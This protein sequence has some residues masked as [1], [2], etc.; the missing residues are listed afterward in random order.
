MEPFS[1]HVLL[2][3]RGLVLRAY[4]S[5]VDPDAYPVEG[6]PV[7]TAAYGLDVFIDRYL[8]PV[9]TY[10]QPLDI[11]AVHDAGN[12][13]RRALYPDYKLKR[14]E[15][16]AGEFEKQQ[17]DLL[18]RLVRDLLAQLGCLQVYCE[19]TEA[20]DVVAYLVEKLHGN[21]AIYTVDEDLVQLATPDGVTV[22]RGDDCFT[23][24]IHG[25]PAELLVLRKSIIGDSSDGYGGVE[26][27]GPKGFDS[28]RDDF[29]IDGLY[30][31]DKIVRTQDWN[32]LA[33]C[34]TGS[35]VI[36]KLYDQRQQ[37]HLCYQLA[38]LHPEICYQIKDRSLRT[39][40][41][42]KRLPSR[43]N[44]ASLL[45][46]TGNTH[47]LEALEKFLP[48]FTLVT[49][50]NLMQVL[51]EIKGYLAENSFAAFDYETYDPVQWEPF[52]RANKRGQY[53]DILSHMP[54]GASFAVGPNNARAYYFSTEHKDTAN[55][56]AGVI[57]GMIQYIEL[58]RK[59]PL[60]A[61]NV[62]FEDAVTGNTFHYRLQSRWDTML[63]QRHLDEEGFSGLKHLSKHYL[64][65][66]QTTYAE[67][68][69][70]AG[71]T[72]AMAA[73]CEDSEGDLPPTAAV[74]MADLTGE[75]VLHYA[76]DDALVTA[77]LLPLMVR[78]GQIEGWWNHV[79]ET[80]FTAAAPLVDVYL[81][82]VPVDYERLD[83]LASEDRK[84]IAAGQVRVRELLQAHCTSASDEAVDRLME[85]LEPFI[86]AKAKAD[87]KTATEATEKVKAERAYFEI[88]GS[89]R[90]WI[91]ITER[92]PFNPTATQLNK[93]GEALGV[94]TPLEKLTKGTLTA[95]ISQAMAEHRPDPDSDLGRFLDLLRHATGK[96]FK[97]LNSP[98]RLAL[99]NFCEG[100]LGQ[101]IKTTW[102]GSELNSGS[103]KQMQA[104][105]YVMLDLPIRLRS[106]VD[107]GSTRE[108]LGFEGAPSTNEKAI[109]VAI[110]E[111]TKGKGLPDTWMPWAELQKA[112]EV[113][114]NGDWKAEVLLT[115]LAVGK[116]Q[117]REELYWTP[118]PLWKH[119]KDGR[120][121]PFFRPSGTETRRPTGSSP[122]LF[123]VSKKDGGYVRSM[124]VPFEPERARVVPTNVEKAA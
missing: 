84:T 21:K 68:L 37:W 94:V 122:N 29:G 19:K 36:Q 77:H 25:I 119:P 116:A 92:I 104:F 63:I 4:H 85:E 88:E 82:G 56:P 45:E 42:L 13:Y 38:R 112:I 123:Q 107:K 43:D 3:L 53:L 51:P 59:I 76:C 31:L 105:L 90:P 40:K 11:I 70:Q 33:A 49:Q 120:I 58:E 117:T 6:R 101:N 83:Y 23:D 81:D 61:H 65:Y 28:L 57:G 22:F 41:W 52:Q 30:E 9:L 20:D 1:F 72:A 39:L 15:K 32:D 124:F 108:Q 110:A 109:K 26:G 80:E 5:G 64:A 44:V 71:H 18:M 17:A 78:L 100:I 99:I 12:E 47:H 111:D 91:E 113:S 67:C 54:T 75:E 96:A 73:V 48:R 118:Y 115:W 14:R 60:A 24:E 8:K 46:Q 10:A 34:C 114:A 121:H 98:E 106:K 95:Y 69:A 102:T 86:R 2:D 79:R 97:E 103:G 87:G 55:V 50:A 93:V 16:L 74:H 35:K 7:N 89:Y 27:V 62:A 66:D